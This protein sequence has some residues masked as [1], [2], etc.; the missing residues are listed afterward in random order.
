MEKR[1]VEG[2]GL[3]V[4]DSDISLALNDG[5]ES[6]PPLNTEDCKRLEAHESDIEPCRFCG[7]PSQLWQYEK[8]GNYVKGVCCSNDDCPMNIPSPLFEV[9]TIRE[10]KKLWHM[11]P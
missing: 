11:R 7:S 9:P 8:S 2:Q 4:K 10:A 6:P 5:L 1:W 3:M